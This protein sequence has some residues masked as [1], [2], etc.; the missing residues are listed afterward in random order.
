MRNAFAVILTIAVFA[1]LVGSCDKPAESD[2]TTPVASTP[3]AAS[4]PAAATPDPATPASSGTQAANGPGTKSAPVAEA[5]I[6]GKWLALF[7]RT[8]GG[9]TLDEAWKTGEIIEFKKGGDM[10]WIKKSGSAPMD[11]K[12]TVDGQS[13]TIT[14]GAQNVGRDDEVGLMNVGRD[15]E[16]GML[17]VG[18]DDEVGLNKAEGDGKTT[19][20]KGASKKTL[21]RDGNFLAIIGEHNDIMVYGKVSGTEP[22][23]PDIVGNYTASIAASDAIPTVF[24]WKENYLLGSFSDFHGNFKGQYTNGYFVGVT[25]GIAANGLAAV[26]QLPDGTLDGVLLSTPFTSMNSNF[27]FNPG[28]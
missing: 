22:A 10:L 4:S 14:P 28:Q 7:G 21:F 17:N 27:N 6:S 19:V 25:N 11:F 8:E 13:L 5:D 9:S 15:D 1:C 16:V 20:G 26:T 24:E 23:R 18:R 12:F 3:P 2:G